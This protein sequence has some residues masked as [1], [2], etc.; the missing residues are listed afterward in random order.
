MDCLCCSCWEYFSGG[1]EVDGLVWF[2]GEGP[3]EV[4]YGG[5]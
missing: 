2:K 4:A 5:W 1:M 3:S